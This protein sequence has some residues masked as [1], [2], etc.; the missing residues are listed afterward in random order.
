M[1]EFKNPLP[2]E[3]HEALELAHKYMRHVVFGETYDTP[4][5]REVYDAVY[6]ALMTEKYGTPE[7]PPRTVKPA[8]SFQPPETCFDCLTGVPFGPDGKHVHS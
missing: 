4:P 8:P 6:K 2:A 5:A 7:P 3:A 1:S